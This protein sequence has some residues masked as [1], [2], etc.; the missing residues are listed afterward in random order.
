MLLRYVSYVKYAL[1]CT[2]KYHPF[3]LM[4]NF[5]FW[6]I[7]TT[8]F[9][10]HTVVHI[11]DITNVDFF[12]TLQ[13][14]KDSTKTSGLHACKLILTELLALLPF[15]YSTFREESHWIGQNRHTDWSEKSH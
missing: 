2:K 5:I 1:F 4:Y 9:Q 6:N 15:L 13:F 10:V 14:V 7:G 12:K 3:F 11:L 8:I